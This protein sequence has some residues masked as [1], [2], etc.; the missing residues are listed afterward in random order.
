MVPLPYR[1]QNLIRI[2]SFMCPCKKQI[3]LYKIR[4]R[5]PYPDDK[6]NKTTQVNNMQRTKNQI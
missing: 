5:P 6:F 1:L 3:D 2:N 4:M